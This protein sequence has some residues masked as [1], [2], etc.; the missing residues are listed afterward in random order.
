[1]SLF[2]E[3]NLDVDAFLHCNDLTYLNNGEE[4]LAKYKK[5]DKLN[6]NDPIIVLESDKKET[7]SL[8]ILSSVKKFWPNFLLGFKKFKYI[9]KI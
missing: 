9:S 6:K 3:E 8:A 1:M 5:G 4:E 7:M 2:D